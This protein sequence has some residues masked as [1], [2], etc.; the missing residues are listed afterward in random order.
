ML[1][2]KKEK[3]KCFD[4]IKNNHYRSEKVNWAKVFDFVEK[5]DKNILNDP[6]TFKI[7]FRYQIIVYLDP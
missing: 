1:N 2:I 5:E 6:N 4:H 3:E 7:N